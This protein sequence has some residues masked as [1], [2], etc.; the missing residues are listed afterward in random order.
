MKA[1]RTCRNCSAKLQA[2]QRFCF[3]CGILIGTSDENILKVECETHPDRFAVG[4][5][6]ICGKPVC[7]DCEVKSAGKI[8]CAD[9]EH[10]VLLQE[11][12]EIHRPDSEFEAEALVRNLADGGVEAK[13]FS[14]HDNVAMHWMNENCVLVFVRKSESSKAK[15]IL[16][17]LNLIEND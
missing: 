17:D 12:R 1:M 5:C 3:D 7:S 16:E 6:V 9:P 15:V 11:W 10:M 8:V 14:L 4:L 2:G 13:T